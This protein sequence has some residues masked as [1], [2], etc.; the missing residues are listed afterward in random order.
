M[1]KLTKLALIGGA[2]ALMPGTALAHGSMMPSH[3]GMVQLSGEI[4]VELV[5]KPGSLEI[6]L[7]EEDQPLAAAGFDATLI[8]TA[9]DGTK[10]RTA[11]SAAGGNRFT[12]PGNPPAGAKVTVSLTGKAGG[13]KTFVTFAMK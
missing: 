2:L 3:G 7:T 5:S 10:S 12:A 4:M 13:A 1:K 11:L 8:V 6:Y 9:P